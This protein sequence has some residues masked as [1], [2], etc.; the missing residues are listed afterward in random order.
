MTTSPLL[1]RLSLFTTF[2]AFSVILLGAY[3]RLADA[4]L[5]CPDWPGCYGHIGV[6]NTPQAIDEANLTYPERPVETAK[7]WKEMVHRYLAGLLGLCILALAILAWRLRQY[8]RQ[9]PSLPILLVG[10]VIFQALL[11]M[12][13]VTLLLQPIIVVAHLLGGMATLALLWW[14]YLRHSQWIHLTHPHLTLNLP[15][16]LRT[17]V[18]IAMGIVVLQISLGGWTSANYAA[19]ACPDFPTCQHAWI[20]SN[21]D[22]SQAFILWHTETTR[23]YAGGVLSSEARIA[24]H[25]IHRV[26]AFITFL[27]LSALC[28]YLFYRAKNPPILKI[29]GL[30]LGAAL[31][32]QISLGITN[33]ML[34]LPLT[35]AV[36]HNG[37]AALLLVVLVTLNHLLYPLKRDLRKRL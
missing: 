11:G 17:A 24:I 19:L 10:L 9:S 5:G 23:D 13:T 3:V 14:Y 16:R 20:P 18:G 28:F 1:A 15:T 4:G 21:A 32:L 6:P 22:W 31:L 8:T 30:L 37:G 35:V 26:G 36:A 34:S 27:Y 2:L 25:F 33:V 29:I 7:A 12:W